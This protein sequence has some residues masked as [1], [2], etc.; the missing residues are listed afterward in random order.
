[1]DI[2]FPKVP[3]DDREWLG[4]ELLLLGQGFDAAAPQFTD[5]VEGFW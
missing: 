1:L 4:A 3:M 2:E 5:V